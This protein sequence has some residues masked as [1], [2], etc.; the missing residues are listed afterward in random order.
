MLRGSLGRR[1][2]VSYLNW[3]FYSNLGP[4]FSRKILSENT[5]FNMFFS[6]TKK[7]TKKIQPADDFRLSLEAGC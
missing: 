3:C 6:L 2:L 1:S 4:I 7:Q 5:S